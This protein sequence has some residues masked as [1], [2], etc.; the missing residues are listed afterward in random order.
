MALEQKWLKERN[1]LQ[2]IRNSD[3]ICDTCKRCT[4]SVVS[5]EVYEIKPVSVL[6]GGVCYE[7]KKQ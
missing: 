6:K 5:C 7:Y 1:P 4:K 3:L 2:P